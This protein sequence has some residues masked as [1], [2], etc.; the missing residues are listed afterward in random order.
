MPSCNLAKMV[1]N[2]WLQQSG[3]RGNDLYV[4]TVVDFVKTLIHV[5][6]Y[7]QYLKGEHKASGLGKEELMLQ[8]A[9]CSAQRSGNPKALNVAMAKMHRTEEFCTWEP[10][11]EG[12]K[13]FGSQKRKADISLGSEHQSHRPDQVNLSHPRVNTRS[14]RVRGISCNLNNIPEE[15]PLDLHEHP[16][17]IDNCRATYVTAIQE[18]TYKEMEWHI[19]R[20]S[21]TSA[22]ACFA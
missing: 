6:R 3:D 20:L 16:T 9:Q 8:V 17:P 13:V 15:L 22:K 10:H 2:K 7:Y 14:T 5:S 18:T 21:K 4:A 11:F 19:A 12:E 1:Y